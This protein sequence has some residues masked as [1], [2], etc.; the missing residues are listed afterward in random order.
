[1]IE[2]QLHGSSMLYNCPLGGTAKWKGGYTWTSVLELANDDIHFEKSENEYL[3]VD[4]SYTVSCDIAVLDNHTAYSVNTKNRESGVLNSCS[5]IIS[6]KDAGLEAVKSYFDRY[7][8]KIKAVYH[9]QQIILVR[10][11]CPDYCMTTNFVRKYNC[12]GK[13]AFNERIQE[14][15]D[16]FIQCVNP[17]VV[18]TARFYYYDSRQKNYGAYTSYEKAF[19]DNTGEILEAIV[20][21]SK[22]QLYNMPPYGH[23]L[24]RYIKYYEIA[25]ERNE[26]YYLIEK[27]TPFGVIVRAMNRDMVGRF[28]YPLIAIAKQNPKSL[29][30]IVEN[31]DFQ[32]FPQLREFIVLVK[33]VVEDR[34]D[35]IGT[36][37][38]AILG[39][40]FGLELDVLV[41]TRQYYAENSYML[42]S[43][44]NRNNTREFYLASKA[45]ENQNYVQAADYI[46]EA[47]MK[48]DK[49]L[50]KYSS[51]KNVP[52]TFLY[53]L[54]YYSC[55]CT[56][57]CIDVW[58]TFGTSK[59]AFDTTGHYQVST[60][61]SNLNC[62]EEAQ[63]AQ[64]IGRLQASDADWLLFDLYSVLSGSKRS[65][66]SD[67]EIESSLDRLIRELQER[68]GDHILLHRLRLK[69][70]YR[71]IDGK[72]IEFSDSEKLKEQRAELDRWQDY[73]L[74]KLQCQVID[75][76]NSYELHESS[77]VIMDGMNY[78][79]AYFKHAHDVL[80]GILQKENKKLYLHDSYI[81]AYVNQN[82]GDDLFIQ[83]LLERYA[84]S[85][86]CMISRNRRVGQGFTGYQNLD[87]LVVN[88]L[89]PVKKCRTHITIGGSVFPEDALWGLKYV[90]RLRLQKK[91]QK[92]YV[93]GAN[94]G[95]YDSPGFLEAYKKL[96]RKYKDV[97][98][99]EKNSYQ[100]FKD[101]KKIRVEPDILFGYP[102][103]QTCAEQE[104]VL[105]SVISL[106]NRPGLAQYAEAYTANMVRLCEDFVQNG[107][108]VCLMS[109]CNN[110]GDKNAIVEIRQQL[111]QETLSQTDMYCYE[112]DTAEALGKIAESK[113][114]VTARF[115]G[116]ILGFIHKKTVY[117]IIY[118]DKTKHMLSDI[119]FEGNFCA[120]SEAEKLTVEAVMANSAYKV[121]CSK[122]S[123]AADRQFLALD[124]VLKR[125]KKQA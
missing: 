48:F 123:E 75:F 112:G 25:Y 60:Y 69:T 82:L 63:Q 94:F 97:C 35:C 61:I 44:I 31:Y 37:L 41:K 84:A 72:N 36:E 17:V 65:E 1:M 13:T 100:L 43:L 38:D 54:A 106:Q 62:A 109:F 57:I 113:Y 22:Q 79:P 118:S 18:D 76:G 119:G 16:Y 88:G 78:E 90:K 107:I 83:M 46:G 26:Q 99:R 28:K 47:V 102:H 52:E 51:K 67:S 15:E 7:I 32:F 70:Q 55:Y 71:T 103:I 74:R 111:T 34:Y 105:I 121:D 66:M 116:A 93:L 3:V 19:Y 95:P 110:E 81:N 29:E 8:E 42:T 21:G 80:C 85:D 125:S 11:S 73:V 58:G 86:F 108:K 45:A 10:T 68:Y 53:A 96:F 6:V 20:K 30:E 39:K 2:L 101:N 12:S 98:F 27:N 89:P 9:R 92:S 117:P 124:K 14:L 33:N 64:A 122:L 4:L 56:P 50:P 24:D 115:H 87:L 77:F 104:Q 23:I 114:V 59:I 120:I 91:I 49:K 40:Q 5:G